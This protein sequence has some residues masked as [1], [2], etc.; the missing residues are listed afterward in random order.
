MNI[1]IY[2]EARSLVE[3]NRRLAQLETVSRGSAAVKVAEFTVKETNLHQIP[4][5]TEGL[6]G[7]GGYEDKVYSVL[8]V[9]S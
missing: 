8:N 9:L 6:R 1:I 7:F 5:E 2:S 4:V 3:S